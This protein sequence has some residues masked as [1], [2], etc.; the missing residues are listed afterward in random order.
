MS[1]AKSQNT[2]NIAISTLAVAPT[3]ILGFT[4][5]DSYVYFLNVEIKC[6]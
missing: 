1:L 5:F 2:T 4:G 6:I 3:M